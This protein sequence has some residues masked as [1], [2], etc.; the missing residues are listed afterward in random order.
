MISVGARARA[1]ARAGAKA[2]AGVRAGAKAE[3]GAEAGVGAAHFIVH[4][5]LG[6]AL[7]LLSRDQHHAGA[8]L[9]ME[10]LKKRQMEK[11]HLLHAVFHHHHSVLAPVAQVVMT[12]NKVC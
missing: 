4:R 11:V 5:L 3:A 10:V 6:T 2:G 9:A 12:R 7:A 8:L 1:R